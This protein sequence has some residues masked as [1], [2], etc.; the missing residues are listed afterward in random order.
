MRDSVDQ[1]PFSPSRSTSIVLYSEPNNQTNLKKKK[2]KSNVS[3]SFDQA[4]AR[5]WG[6]SILGVGF[7]SSRFFCSGFGGV[8]EGGCKESRVVVL[9]VFLLEVE[10]VVCIRN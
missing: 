6:C 7:A 1:L 3:I 2:K 4:Q 9:M 10:H 5:H 8:V